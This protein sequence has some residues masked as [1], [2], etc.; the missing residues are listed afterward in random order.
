[1]W[2]WVTPAW[3]FQKFPCGPGT[4]VPNMGKQR[5]F[6]SSQSGH[7]RQPLLEDGGGGE[8]ERE[9]RR[10]GRER[11]REALQTS[12]YKKLATNKDVHLRH[13]ASCRDA[14]SGPQRMLRQLQAWCLRWVCSLGAPVISP[15]SMSPPEC[16]PASDWPLSHRDS[17]GAGRDHPCDD[18]VEDDGGFPH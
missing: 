11:W 5:S 16:G 7:S 3:M 2:T 15:P 6:S 14:V 9:G 18:A 8:G 12:Y 17:R 10:V 1:M 4:S 13:L